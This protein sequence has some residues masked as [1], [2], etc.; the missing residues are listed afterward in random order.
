MRDVTMT[1]RI[2]GAYNCLTNDQSQ[3]R[4]RLAD[5]RAALPYESRE[6]VDAEL[7]AMEDERSITLY[8]LDNPQEIHSADEAANLP[9]GAGYPRHIVYMK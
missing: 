6:A 7:M 5:L 3:V 2:K 8:P 1:D 4:V 9:N